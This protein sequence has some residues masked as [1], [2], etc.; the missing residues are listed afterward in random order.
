M[1]QSSIGQASGHNYTTSAT[2]LKYR[3]KNS[4]NPLQHDDVDANFDI[5]RKAI[6]GIVTDISGVAGNTVSTNVPANAVFTDTQLTTAE[7]RS[8]FSAGSNITITNGVIAGSAPYTHPNH[9]GDVT[10]AGDGATTIATGAVTEA[11]IAAGAITS[12]KIAAGAVDTTKLVTTGSTAIDL[13]QVVAK[14]LIIHV[15]NYY[16]KTGTKL[17]ANDGLAYNSTADT[18][19]GRDLFTVK[20][21][22]AD[23]PHGWGNNHYDINS[24]HITPPFATLS[25]ASRF[26]IQN[27][28]AGVSVMFIIH[29]HVSWINNLDLEGTPSY[30]VKDVGNWGSFENV[31]IIGG[32]PPNKNIAGSHKTTF[33]ENGV[34][35]GRLD[36]DKTAMTL[37]KLA[38]W[39]RGPS[40][41]IEGINFVFKNDSTST[42]ANAADVKLRWSKG[43]GGGGFHNSRN[44]RFRC[45]NAS[46]N[47]YFYPLEHNE[48]A[49][50]YVNTACELSINRH[51][52]IAECRNGSSITFFTGGGTMFIHGDSSNRG[53]RAGGVYNS[54][55]WFMAP[56]A[57]FLY[58]SKYVPD[59]TINTFGFG[60]A[61]GIAAAYNSGNYYL[62]GDGSVP[63]THSGWFNVNNLGN[64]YNGSPQATLVGVGSS[65]NNVSTYAASNS[66]RLVNKSSGWTN[67]TG[68]TSQ[69]ILCG[70]TN[71]LGN[72][73]SRA[74]NPYS[75]Q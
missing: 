64:L 43:V 11:K 63:V 9:S 57:Q 39:F 32:A 74:S 10:S 23:H 20:F 33:S 22:D 25:A 56:N 49:Q 28:G 21:S 47:G 41:Q 30:K 37:T 5:L 3:T 52:T 67:S 36:F 51:M 48:G 65:N 73:T 46:S 31:C 55:S 7:V 50:H 45:T 68:V 17:Y 13:T 71:F 40:V 34:T 75:T 66:L 8:K 26:A 61:F 27:F 24:S 18:Y 12:T 14:S 69:E 4:G 2:A 62:C 29:G 60:G 58:S 54:S 6:N 16:D 70:N 44:V 53:I 38:N 42:N 72:Q 19:G 59:G 15:G 1:A 35:V